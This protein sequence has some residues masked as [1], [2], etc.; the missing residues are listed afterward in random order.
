MNLFSFFFQD[1]KTSEPDPYEGQTEQELEANI[2]D[3]EKHYLAAASHSSLGASII[4]G[5]LGRALA[6]AE[7]K[8]RSM[9]VKRAHPDYVCPKCEKPDCH[10]PSKGHPVLKLTKTFLSRLLMD[11]LREI[12]LKNGETLRIELRKGETGNKSISYQIL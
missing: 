1:K 2:K 7:A 8:L 6:N 10:S 11:F 5:Q 4:R 12:P 9:K 3:L